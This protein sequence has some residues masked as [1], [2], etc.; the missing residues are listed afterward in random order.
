MPCVSSDQEK[1]LSAIATTSP[2]V[3]PTKTAILRNSR[4]IALCCSS[5][6]CAP[7]ALY[8]QVTRHLRLRK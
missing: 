1:T 8:P 4:I 2:V 5:V 3:M 6:M 7:R